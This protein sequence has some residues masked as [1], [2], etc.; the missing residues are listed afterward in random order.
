MGELEIESGKVQV[1][2]QSLAPSALTLDLKRPGPASITLTLARLRL[3]DL[4]CPHPSPSR[5]PSTHSYHSLLLPCLLVTSHIECLSTPSPMILFSTYFIT[6][7]RFLWTKMRLMTVSCGGG[8]RSAKAASG[9]TR[10]RMF[11][12]SGD[13]LSFPRHLAS[14]FPSSAHMARL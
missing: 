9:G 11:A 6:A 14:V 2:K 1:K 3:A 5:Q 12:E 13:S 7:G 4:F 10:S 8:N